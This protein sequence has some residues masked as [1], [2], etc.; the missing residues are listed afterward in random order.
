MKCETCGQLLPALK[1]GDFVNVDAGNGSSN[2]RGLGIV[3]S[4][5]NGASVVVTALIGP[6]A[7][8]SLNPRR[9]RVTQVH[10]YIHVDR[11]PVAGWT[12]RDAHKY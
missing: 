9:E 12:E 4:D 2:Y 5:T 3:T 10:G 7:G 11:I 1:R 8:L 6:M